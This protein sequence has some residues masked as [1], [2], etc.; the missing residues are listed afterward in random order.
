MD[1]LPNCDHFMNDVE[2]LRNHVNWHLEND[3]KYKQMPLT[4]RLIKGRVKAGIEQYLLRKLRKTLNS[5]SYN[6][7]DLNRIMQLF[8]F[9]NEI[10]FQ[11]AQMNAILQSPFK[12]EQITVS[13][14]DRSE[15]SGILKG[16]VKSNFMCNVKLVEF[17]T[18]SDGFS[19]SEC[20]LHAYY[21]LKQWWDSLSL[22][23]RKALRDPFEVEAI[24]F[25]SRFTTETNQA[26][27]KRLR[28]DRAWKTAMAFQKIMNED[29]QESIPC[30]VIDE[31]N[32][33][34]GGKQLYQIYASGAPID[35]YPE[36]VIDPQKNDYLEYMPNKKALYKPQHKA[37][38][39]NKQRDR[40]CMLLFK[41]EGIKNENGISSYQKG[42]SQLVIHKLDTLI[43]V[44]RKDESL[45]LNFLQ[46]GIAVISN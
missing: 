41:L 39:D 4:E 37:L 25:S 29:R 14:V 24:G 8:N 32:I 12:T 19:E 23:T 46:P 2:N 11:A 38:T 35:V 27:N 34:Y 15:L 7:K 10:D 43:H 21:Q 5:L 6:G 18:G 45:V 13:D 40:I 42:Q 33:S 3:K 36:K 1:K 9:G 26:D 44:S 22:L 17:A 31:D 20:P 16:K 28:R 30:E